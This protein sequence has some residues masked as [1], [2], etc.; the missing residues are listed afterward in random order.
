MSVLHKQNINDGNKWVVAKLHPSG[1][2]AYLAAQEIVRKSIEN[3]D[4]TFKEMLPI[5][6]N[7]NKVSPGNEVVLSRE[8]IALYASGQKLLPRD[9]IK[10]IPLSSNST[11][12]TPFRV[13]VIATQKAFDAFNAAQVRVKLD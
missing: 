5:K 7:F 8:E 11:L 3:G 12:E 2:P 10:F 13:A 1:Q 4:L 9:N 6:V